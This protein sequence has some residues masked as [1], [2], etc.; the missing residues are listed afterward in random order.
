MK[1]QL[2][3]LFIAFINYL[4]FAQT[5]K[6]FFIPAKPNNRATY[7]SANISEMTRKIFY[8][9]RDSLY[10]IMDV[11]LFSGK[12]ITN[13]EKTLIISDKEVKMINSI[14]TNMKE[15][16]K[17][18]LHNPAVII[19]KLPPFGD[20]ITWSY[21]ETSGDE[22]K[23]TSS[24]TKITING[25]ILNAIKIYKVIGSSGKQIDCTEYYVEGYGYY[26]TET[27]DESGKIKPFELCSL[28]DFD[29]TIR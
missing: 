16:N 7:Y 9:E 19:F 25:K 11:K 22:V 8:I 3:T 14:S 4:T 18:R 26:K 28:I 27:K 10:E 5:A 1:R 24:W 29:P 23:C 20:K 21:K 6:S 13:I 15:T 17:A 2:L 12:T